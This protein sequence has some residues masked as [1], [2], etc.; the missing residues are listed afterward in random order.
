MQFQSYF[1]VMAAVFLGFTV[2]SPMAQGADAVEARVRFP[3]A[4]SFTNLLSP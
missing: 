4:V 1:A 3:Q 2:A